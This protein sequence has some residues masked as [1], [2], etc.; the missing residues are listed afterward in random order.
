MSLNEV[1]GILSSGFGINEAP[2]ARLA[3]SRVRDEIYDNNIWCLS[4]SR[5]IPSFVCVVETGVVLQKKGSVYC[6]WIC[7]ERTFLA[8]L[9]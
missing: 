6:C 1:V 4:E 8:I 5:D 7:F 9:L 2:L 3:E